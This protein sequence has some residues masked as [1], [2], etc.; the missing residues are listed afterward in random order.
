VY[1]LNCYD[2]THKVVCN[3]KTLTSSHMYM[4]CTTAAV[5]VQ[6]RSRRAALSQGALAPHSDGTRAAGYHIGT[7]EHWL[8]VY[9]AQASDDVRAKG[10]YA[11]G[12]QLISKLFG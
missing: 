2:A 3:S 7:C 12:K 5:R 8:S 4:L 1:A 10:R 11:L 6:V 9:G